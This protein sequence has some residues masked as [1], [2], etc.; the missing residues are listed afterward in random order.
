MLE[1]LSR[2]DTLEKRIER[3]FPMEPEETTE[4]SSPFAG[5]N[6]GDFIPEVSP[7]LARPN[8]LGPLMELLRRMRHE[9]VFAVCS[10]PPR[11]AKTETILHD[12]ALELADDPTIQICYAGYAQRFAENKSRKARQIARRAGVPISKESSSRS[13]WRTGHE[14]GGLWATSIGGPITGEGF[15]RVFIDDPVK[16]R[17]IAE[18]AVYREAAWEWFNDDVFTRIE[19]GGSCLVNM[20]RWHPDDLGGR[21]IAQGWE[22]IRL[23]AIDDNGVALWPER[24]SVEHLEKV[25]K[26]VGPYTWESLYQGQPRARG[27]RVFGDVHF[28]TALPEGYRVTVG[29]DFA[30]SAKTHA[31]Y[32]V[33]VVMAHKGD[34]HFVI[35]VVRMQAR[36]EEFGRTLSNLSKKYP[37]ARFHAYTSTTE[38]GITGLLHSLGGV[39]IHGEVAGADKFVRAQPVAAAWN[40]GHILL[41]ATPA[42]ETAP[43]WLDPY[44]SELCEFT[45]VK[46]RNDDQVDATASAF[47]SGAVTQGDTPRVFASSFDAGTPATKSRFQW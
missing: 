26:Q 44:V 23:P 19:P 5:H 17:A 35:E 30:Y 38:V 15:H 2:I 7:K 11:H 42:D 25:R 39:P 41:P 18:S 31:D 14:D 6:L 22:H 13:N 28:Y 4:R 24:W 9:A 3:A 34:F 37:G 20:T 1:F 12:I 32:S 16:S 21:L 10:T 8:H 45:G 36:A 46:D 33:A 47:D 40:Q 43:L 27:G 29:V